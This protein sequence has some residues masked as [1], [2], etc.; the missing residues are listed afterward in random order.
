MDT[1]FD[2]PGGFDRD[3]LAEALA[4]LAG[5]GIYIGTSSWKYEGWLGQVYSR[6]NYLSRGRF[7]R[8]FF[9]AECLREYAR[10][11]PAVCGDFSFYQFPSEDYWR[12]LFG[13]APESFRFAFKVP[14]QITCKTFPEHERY[15]R[16]GGTANEFFLNAALLRESFLT[17][18]EPYRSRIGALIFE[19]GTF[20][21]RGMSGLSEFM[22]RLDEFL[23]QLPPEFR[24]AVEVRNPEFLE[25]RYFDL[26]RSRG[27]AY[28][29]NAWTRM[30]ELRIQLQIP[31][32]ETADFV[33]CRALLRRSR[34]YEEAVRLFTP[35]DQVRDPNPDAREALRELVRRAREK[36][37]LA[38]L[39]VNNRLEGNA[40]ETIRAVACD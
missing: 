2:E 10:T 39:F 40:P 15:G 25:P 19:F 8:K 7:S 3:A 16:L 22:E 6:S 28:V 9:E 37:Q 5:E 24:Y 26:L 33:V 36:R 23:V 13:M 35:Y 32:A 18:L 27:A 14:E 17:P 31:H 38:F 29:Y 20:S 12:R 4:A 21:R 1:L 34:P 30:P 11:F